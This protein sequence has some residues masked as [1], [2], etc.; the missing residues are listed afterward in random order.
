MP[1]SLVFLVLILSY[2]EQRGSHLVLGQILVSKLAVG[3]FHTHELLFSRRK[4]ALLPF[5]SRA[6]DLKTQSSEYS[7]AY[8]GLQPSRESC[9]L[10][11]LPNINSAWDLPRP[12]VWETNQTDLCAHSS[13]CGT[14]GGGRFHTIRAQLLSSRKLKSSWGKKNHKHQ[15]GNCML[16]LMIK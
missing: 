4:S 14:A 16:W 12:L 1:K 8:V 3:C 7:L 15:V 9:L 13:A 5:L 10:S 6:G 2:A 11:F